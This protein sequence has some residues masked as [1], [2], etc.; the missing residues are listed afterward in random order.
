MSDD[1][2]PENDSP[3]V[4]RGAEDPPEPGSAEDSQAPTDPLAA[5]L[6][7][8]DKYLEM[9]RRARADFENYQMRMRRDLEVERKYAAMPMVRDLL[10]ALDNFDRA[11]KS[12]KT[13]TDAATIVEGLEIVRRQMVDSFARHGVAPI[14]PDGQ[15]FDPNEHEAIVQ[16]P[17][18][19]VPPMTVL[20]TVET[21]FK[22]HDRVVRPAK[23]IVS[24]APPE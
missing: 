13:Q 19:E 12:A 16:Q 8:R 2:T 10:P 3:D 21:G 6:A 22:L 9:A 5:A 11:L 23:V 4:Q 15:P 18:N 17:S 1:P 14:A 20:M 7:E 24:S